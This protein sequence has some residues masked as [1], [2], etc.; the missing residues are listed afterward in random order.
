VSSECEL[1]LFFSFVFFLVTTVRNSDTRFAVNKAPNKFRP[2][3]VT[4][5]VIVTFLTGTVH[6]S[7][8][9]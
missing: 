4:V 2:V 7:P 9:E 6:F 5:S 1:I 8:Q 3:E